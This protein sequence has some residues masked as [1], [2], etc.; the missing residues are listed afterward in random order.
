[1]TAC[2]K[3]VTKSCS[4]EVCLD[5]SGLSVIEKFAAL[6]E[7]SGASL[8]TGHRYALNE[9]T[10][11]VAGLIDWFSPGHL[12]SQG[13]GAG[14]QIAPPARASLFGGHPYYTFTGSQYY[15]S[16][17]PASAWNFLHNPGV[18][19]CYKLAIYIVRAVGF[20]TLFA[21]Y[22]QPD[23][24]TQVG[25][26]LFVNAGSNNFGYNVARANATRTLAVN[27]TLAG[28]AVVRAVSAEYAETGSSPEWRTKNNG[29]DISTGTS[30]AAPS[31]ADASGT[32][33]VGAMQVTA[34]SF[35]LGD[36][37]LLF[38]LPRLPTTSERA[39]IQTL[40]AAYQVV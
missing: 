34:E 10:N 33:R 9:P 22:R 4:K 28:T 13:G 35:F 12:L 15:D 17:R 39:A 25:S 27:S 18:Q 38:T 19:G 32:L 16:S 11:T 26:V 14:L 31:S 36:L 21:T 5:V 1:M 40:S 6:F 30:S 37:A 29:V 23:F 2:S 3:D 8:F 20:R 7:G 24:A